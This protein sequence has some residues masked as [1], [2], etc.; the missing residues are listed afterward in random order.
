MHK[1]VRC[2]THASCDLQGWYLV[3]KPGDVDTLAELHQGIAAFYYQQFGLDPHKEVL[4]VLQNPIWLADMWLRTI[5]KQLFNG[6]RMLINSHGGIL[7]H[8]D[9]KVWATATR[10][11]MIWPGEF[12]P[13]EFIT[14]SRWPKGF[15]FY[16]SSN[17]ER[18]FTPPKYG[19]LEKALEAAEFYTNNIKVKI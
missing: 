13:E 7:P 5:E 4:G 10:A 11:K 18:I 1:F 17:K 14:I 12:D 16:L 19:T 15:H 8:C 9:V 6:V 3:L 2:Q